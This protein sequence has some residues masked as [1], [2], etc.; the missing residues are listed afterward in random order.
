MAEMVSC[1]VLRFVAPSLT[2]AKDR[3]RGGIVWQFGDFTARDCASAKYRLRRGDDDRIEK[4]RNRAIGDHPIGFADHRLP[5]G[6][7]GGGLS[8]AALSH[9]SP[10]SIAKLPTN[11]ETTSE[12]SDFGSFVLSER[13]K[14]RLPLTD[15]FGER[16]FGAVLLKQEGLS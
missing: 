3:P 10:A 1:R 12:C 2:S 8:P 15:G 14:P 13:V 11:N 5:C 7:G 16:D 9:C 4:S 6:A